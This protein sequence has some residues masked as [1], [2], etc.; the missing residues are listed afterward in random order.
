MH[1]GRIVGLIM[2]LVIL[3]TVFVIPITTQTLYSKISPSLT[4][5]A[6]LQQ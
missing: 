6:S 4:N 3:I 5:L 1:P 2:G